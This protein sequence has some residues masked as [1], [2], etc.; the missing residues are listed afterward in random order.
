MKMFTPKK[1]KALIIGA[2]G[3]AGQAF[4]K[5]LLL[6]GFHT[7]GLSRNGPDIFMDAVQEEGEFR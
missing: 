1:P 3:M 2:S 4:T 5:E 6:A 7:Q